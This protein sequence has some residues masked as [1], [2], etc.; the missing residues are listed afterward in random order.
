[1]D[2]QLMKYPYY[3]GFK[4]DT[5]ELVHS[6]LASIDDKCKKMKASKEVAYAAT[7]AENKRVLKELDK[8]YW[9]YDCEPQP[10]AEYEEGACAAIKHA[11][12]KIES[13]A[14]GAS[15]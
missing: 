14:K 10:S 12:K 15:K 7:L 2:E 6:H 11:M 13:S 4:Q 3:C 5:C 1:M 8:L 9:W